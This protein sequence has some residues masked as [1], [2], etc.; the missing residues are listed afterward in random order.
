MT[1]EGS[2]PGRG[3]NCS[4]TWRTPRRLL[5]DGTRILIR[6]T[7]T[8]L[9]S[10][11][12]DSKCIYVVFLSIT[13]DLFTGWFLLGFTLFRIFYQYPFLGGMWCYE[14]WNITINLMSY[15]LWN[16][17]KSSQEA[18]ETWC[19]LL[20]RLCC[21]PL[22]VPGAE[23]ASL[24]EFGGSEPDGRAPL[25]S[26]ETAV[27]IDPKHHPSSSPTLNSREECVPLMALEVV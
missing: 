24:L 22:T 25:C 23:G 11:Q 8:F 4:R 17:A 18:D 14:I 9:I 5:S 19:R 20:L 15:F 6:L 13:W 7:K 26:V 16:R 12:D 27:T 3:P 10:I 2:Q 1:G 21:V